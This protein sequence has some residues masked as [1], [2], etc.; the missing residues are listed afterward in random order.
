MSIFISF[1]L[2]TTLT[3]D[4][5]TTTDRASGGLSTIRSPVVSTNQEPD[6]ATTT[7]EIA[8]FTAIQDQGDVTT[9]EIEASPRSSTV[10]AFFPARIS[11]ST[12]RVNFR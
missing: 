8:A 10:D 5:D 11:S 2:D 1:S 4:A 9:N 3:A 7:N 12:Q 6:M